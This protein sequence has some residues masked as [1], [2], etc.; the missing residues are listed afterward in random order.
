L[1]VSEDS[2]F[3]HYLKNH[4]KEQIRDFEILTAHNSSE[5]LQLAF[6]YNPDIIAS[7][8]QLPGED[9][10]ELCRKLKTKLQT[11]SI[12]F[13]MLV[14]SSGEELMSIESGADEVLMEPFKTDKLV[15][16]ISAYFKKAKRQEK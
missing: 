15:A 4:L 9:G 16:K 2:S 10:R 5:A 11:R 3:L 14:S 7:E 12:Y 6:R 1:L 13:I 8:F